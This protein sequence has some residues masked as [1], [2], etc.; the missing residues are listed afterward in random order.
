MIAAVGMHDDCGND[1]MHYVPIGCYRRSPRQVA[2]ELAEFD[3]SAALEGTV[4]SEGDVRAIL[5]DLVGEINAAN[6]GDQLEGYL[7]YLAA[8][9]NDRLT[10]AGLP[11]IE[12]VG[13]RE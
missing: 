11:T 13:F 10:T 3:R 6:A 12:Q 2:Q 1:A 9:Y 7:D 8:D 5:R 4:A